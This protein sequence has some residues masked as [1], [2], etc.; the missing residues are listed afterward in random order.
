[1]EIEQI[2]KLLKPCNEGV[3]MNIWELFFVQVQQKSNLLMEVHRVN[4]PNSLYE[5]A[6]DVAL[7]N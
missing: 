1:M 6:Q 4:D 5:S 3:K 2:I 7:H